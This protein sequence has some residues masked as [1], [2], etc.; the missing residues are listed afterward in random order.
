MARAIFSNDLDGSPARATIPYLGKLARFI[1]KGA[2][3]N[4]LQMKDSGNRATSEFR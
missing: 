3:P 4:G 2:A 1:P